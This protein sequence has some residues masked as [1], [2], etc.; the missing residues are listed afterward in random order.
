[1]RIFMYRYIGMYKFIFMY[2]YIYILRSLY[3]YIYMYVYICIHIY[4]YVY[5][6]I[7]IHIYIYTYIHIYTYIYIFNSG[8]LEKVLKNC[9]IAKMRETSS[10]GM[11]HLRQ[12][13]YG[14]WRGVFTVDLNEFFDDVYKYRMKD[15]NLKFNFGL[16]SMGQSVIM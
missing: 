8:I 11:N 6:Y 16:N 7:Y 5:M 15:S 1:M 2:I 4:I 13:G 14:G 12:G 3:M 10:I 9:S